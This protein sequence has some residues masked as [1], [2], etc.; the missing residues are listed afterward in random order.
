[1]GWCAEQLCMSGN[2]FGDLVKRE[3]GQTAG[4]HIR[5]MVIELAKERL[6]DG[7]PVSTIAYDLGFDY[8]Q[9]MTRLFKKYVGCSPSEYV[10]KQ[11]K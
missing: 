7:H 6:I 1:M 4:E 2:Y 11:G 8:P 9:H 3:T 5:R 10:R